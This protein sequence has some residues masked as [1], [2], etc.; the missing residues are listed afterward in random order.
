MII[1]QNAVKNTSL[2]LYNV[3]F[4]YGVYLEWRKKRKEF[5]IVLLLET[6]Y[7]FVCFLGL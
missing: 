2:V 4:G 1:Y 6:S 3:Q 7:K 5:P